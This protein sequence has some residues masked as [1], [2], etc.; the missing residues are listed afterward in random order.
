MRL[1]KLLNVLKDQAVF[2]RGEFSKT[3]QVYL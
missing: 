1:S 3:D 2:V